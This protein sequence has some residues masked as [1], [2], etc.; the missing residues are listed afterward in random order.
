MSRFFVRVALNA[1]I[2]ISLTGA[3]SAGDP[4]PETSARPLPSAEQSRILAALDQPTEFDFQQ[5]SLAEAM[6]YFERKHQIE[7]HLDAKTPNDAG[8]G[9]DTPITEA[10]RN[11]SLRSALKLLLRPLNLTYFAGDGYLLITSK[12]A[13][14]PRMSFKVYPVEDL[15]ALDSPFRPAAPMPGDGD[16]APIQREVLKFNQTGIFGGA[17]ATADR[18]RDEAGDY[19]SL[20]KVITETIAPTEWDVVGGPGSITGNGN[21]QAIAVSQTDE[22]HEQIFAMLAALRR[23]RDAQLAA[24]K[25]FEPPPPAVPE[26]EARLQ[27]RAYRLMRGTGVPNKSSWRPVASF[28]GDARPPRSKQTD[29]QA[30]AAAK[31]AVDATAANGTSPGKDASP[32][33]KPEPAAQEADQASPAGADNS[34]ESLAAMIARLVP[35]IIEPESW[36]PLGEGAIVA[37]GEGVVVQNTA[38][39]QR[40]VATLMIELLPDCVPMGFTGPWGPWNVAVPTG[41]HVA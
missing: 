22:V 9:D 25:P 13:T 15:V 4:K 21:I 35:T 27:V 16:D 20:I 6:N 19:A 29:G 26:K 31:P 36:K 37:A 33:E 5:R 17:S 41:R 7:I 11:I 3:A 2:C 1:G 28:V 39:V 24:A 14:T 30:K 23:V 32:A 18:R 8:I 40:R 34:L 12:A 10:L 38:Q